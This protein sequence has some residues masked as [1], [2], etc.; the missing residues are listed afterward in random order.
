MPGF[1]ETLLAPFS[2]GQVNNFIDHWYDHTANIRGTDRDDARGKAEQLKCAVRGSDRLR[3]LAERPLLL[4]LMASLHAW[5]GGTLPERREELYAD[6]VNLLLDLW[7][8]PKTVCEADRTVR[9][10]QPSIGEWLKVD[11]GKVRTLLNRLA[12]RAHMSQPEVTGTADIQESELVTGLMALSNNPEVNPSKLVEFLIDRA[13]ILLPRGVGIYTFPHRTFQE[14]LAACHLTDADFPEET[15]K[16]VR[17]EP[18][19]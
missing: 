15:A 3:A 9:V 16:L 5:R 11:R 6:T 10:L 19:R 14:Y 8:N 1:S 7:V 17:K 13:G 18:N 2:K 4:T 12:F